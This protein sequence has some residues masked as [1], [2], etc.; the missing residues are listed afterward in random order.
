[1]NIDFKDPLVIKKIMACYG[2]ALVE[3]AHDECALIF[4]ITRDEAKKLSYKVFY[5]AD[6]Y[7]CKTFQLRC[8]ELTVLKREFKVSNE[9][10]YGALDK[11]GVYQWFNCG[12][13]TRFTYS[14]SQVAQ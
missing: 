14:T 9:Y 11:S 5:S 4:G 1:M 13:R 2:S 8:K 12:G 7:I 10:L 3:N 6:N